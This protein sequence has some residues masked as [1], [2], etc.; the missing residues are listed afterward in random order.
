MMENIYNLKIKKSTNYLKKIIIHFVN[1]ETDP[2]LRY[3]DCALVGV[4]LGHIIELPV[5]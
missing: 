3:I 2:R 5:K 4:P 1:V